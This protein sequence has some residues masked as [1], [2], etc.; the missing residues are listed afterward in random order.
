MDLVCINQLVNQISTLITVA[1]NQFVKVIWFVIIKEVTNTMRD[2]FLNQYSILW[3]DT[4]VK[5][6]TKLLKKTAQWHKNFI[7]WDMNHQRMDWQEFF[8]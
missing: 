3:A 4:T 6:I 1:L 7:R 8:W 5:I 2:Q